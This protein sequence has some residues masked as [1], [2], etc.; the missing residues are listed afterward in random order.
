MFYCKFQLN[1]ECDDDSVFSAEVAA[2]GNKRE[3]RYQVAEFASELCEDNFGSKVTMVVYRAKPTVF[4]MLA[5]SDDI[6]PLTPAKAQKRIEKYLADQMAQ[7]EYL[8]ENIKISKFEEITT[9]Q[10]SKICEQANRADFIQEWYRIAD[11][12]G[13]NCL[14]NDNFKL[15]ETIFSDKKFTHETAKKKAGKLLADATFFE[16]LDRIYSGENAK[17]FYG[18]PVHYKIVAGNSKSAQSLATLLAEALYANK[19]LTNRRINFFTNITE[20]SYF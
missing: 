17:R 1:Y 5:A 20:N 10:F 3:W 19:R 16:E 18:Q 8:M 15:S 13:I 2:T 11:S 7:G 4:S 6:Q 9:T 14:N 12:T